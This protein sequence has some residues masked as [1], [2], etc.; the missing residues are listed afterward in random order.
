MAQLSKSV[1]CPLALRLLPGCES[2]RTPPRVGPPAPR[3]GNSAAEERYAEVLHRW[4][5]RREIYPFI[6][7]LWNAYMVRFP[8]AFPDGTPVL[9]KSGQV[10]LLSSSLGA[11]DLVHDLDPQ[12]AA[13]F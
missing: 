6:E 4:T 12:P 11:A 8:L 9:P 2:M 10:T 5:R 1:A 3:V 7:Q 13:G